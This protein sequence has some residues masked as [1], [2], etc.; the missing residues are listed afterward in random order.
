MEA[1][2]QSKKLEQTRQDDDTFTKEVESDQESVE[3]KDE[4]FTSPWM[5]DVMTEY[6]V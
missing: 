6:E 2:V 3:A 5:E 1:C 4:V